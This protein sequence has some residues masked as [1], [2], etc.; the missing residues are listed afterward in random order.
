MIRGIAF[1]MDDTLYHE[2]DYVRS[3][4]SVVATMAADAADSVEVLESWLWRAFESGVRGDTFDRFGRRSPQ[5]A[6]GSQ[7]RT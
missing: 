7:R 2:R 3:G 6:I 4:F 5:S 1:D